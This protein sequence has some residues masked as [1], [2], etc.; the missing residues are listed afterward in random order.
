MEANNYRALATYRKIPVKSQGLY[1][2][3]GVFIS[4]ASEKY[5]DKQASFQPV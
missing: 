4:E 3:A 2:F 5:F 1:N